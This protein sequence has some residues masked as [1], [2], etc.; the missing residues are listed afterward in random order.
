MSRKRRE[1]QARQATVPVREAW[2]DLVDIGGSV[3]DDPTWRRLGPRGGFPMDRMGGRDAPTINTEQDLT[4]I[5]SAARGLCDI[6]NTAQAVRRNLLNYVIGPGFTYDVVPATGMDPPEGLVPAARDL[7]FRFLESNNWIAK[8]E[9]ELYWRGV[10]DGEFFLAL[11]AGEGGDVVVREVEPEY[12]TEPP[13]I[14]DAEGVAGE[15]PDGRASSWTFGV[16]TADDD[17]QQVHGFW[18][19]WN[20]APQ[21]YDYLPV[22][23]GL[24]EC[25]GVHHVKRNVDANV[26]RGLSDFY[27][28]LERI[29]DLDKSLRNIAKAL[30]ILSAIAMIQQYPANATK[31]Q[32]ESL[33]DA[34][35][36]RTRTAMTADGGSRTIRE[37]IYSPGTVVRVRGG[38]QYLPGPLATAGVGDAFSKL[39]QAIFRSVGIV[40]CMPEYMVSGDSSNASYSSAMV[41]E[42]PWV[43]FCEREQ[44]LLRSEWNLILWNVLKIAHAAGR[45]SRY[46][47]NYEELEKLLTLVI[48]PPKVATRDHS[49]ETAINQIHRQVGLLSLP[50]WAAEEGYDFEQEK[51]LGAEPQQTAGQVLGAQGPS[52]TSPGA[53]PFKDTGAQ[54]VKDK[55]AEEVQAAE[56]L[57]QLTE[58]ARRWRKYP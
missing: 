3:N 41:A 51:R 48:K 30:A 46:G 53:A 26:K 8:R 9:A 36:Y 6:S 28:V 50:T 16:R 19:H 23:G 54:A 29:A 4:W 33:R 10:R 47:V 31:A 45:F 40:W 34:A 5:R 7:I 17:V 57:V 24:G 1:R 18:C 42:S 11:Y 2:G 21:N 27:P 15:A 56:S 52:P 32:I 12:I 35:T 44:A 49:K 20:G 14:R 58:A 13:S 55:A 38:Q 43:K 22:E 25:W 37:E 39:E